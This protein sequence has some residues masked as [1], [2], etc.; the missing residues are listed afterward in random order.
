MC[1]PGDAIHRI[2]GIGTAR[3]GAGRC[4]PDSS[5][6]GEMMTRYRRGMA[7]TEVASQRSA[8]PMPIPAL[9]PPSRQPDGG[10]M[11]TRHDDVRTVLS[12][13][14]YEVPTVTGTS[15]VGTIAW[16]RA[17]VSRFCNGA[18]HDH[19]RA[20]VTGEIQA[21]SPAALRA[22]AE[23]RAAA[24][25]DAAAG[26]G[27]LEVMTSLARR[28]P[29][30]VLAAGLG[31]AEPERAA[32]AAIVTATAYFPGA[33]AASER[34]ADESTAELVRL[35]GQADEEVIAARIAVLIQGCDATAA[36][37]G[38]A[39]SSVLPPAAERPDWPTDA[40]VAEVARLDPP[41][42]G[43][44]RVSRADAEL[45][46]CP[47]PVGS[48]VVLRLDAA[49]RDPAA[50]A[51]PSGFDPGRSQS[52]SLT[53]GYGVRPCPGA[54]QA[55]M[56]AAGVVQAIRDRCAAVVSPAEYDPSAAIRVPIRLEVSLRSAGV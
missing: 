15:P 7:D 18:E 32:E 25:L 11:I 28:V 45:D 3:L 51:E 2:T 41:A 46:G 39:V 19:R 55:L 29:M 52:A 10:W 16:L 31:F 17:S 30:A 43:M 22:D 40:I 27:R 8:D 5:T 33:D 49:N 21:L 42:R 4:G 13:P 36:L 56:L 54:D 14:R 9:G 23:R 20:V 48:A 47:I 50:F 53:F 1:L 12:D 35:T 44:R 34:A 38:K 6:A 24:V 37:I 26:A